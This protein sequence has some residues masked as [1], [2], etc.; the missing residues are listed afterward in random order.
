MVQ[1]HLVPI[2]DPDS[3]IAAG[4]Y[5]EVDGRR[6]AE[7]TEPMYV[8]GSQ[9]WFSY[10]MVPVSAD[11]EDQER[12]FTAEFWSNG[13]AVFRSRKLGV[14]AVNALPSMTPPSKKTR[15][16]LVRGLHVQLNGGDSVVQ[17]AIRLFKGFQQ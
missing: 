9:F 3:V 2:D 5:V 14:V 12:L 6:M 15:R 17:K 13:K 10:V 1:H 4:W 11:P 8:T 16:L 7:L